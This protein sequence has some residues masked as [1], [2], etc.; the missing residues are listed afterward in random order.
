MPLGAMA[1]ARPCFFSVAQCS[2]STSSTDRQPSD[3]ATS[4]VL[5]TLHLS[6]NRLKHQKTIDCLML[7]FSASAGLSSAPSSEATAGVRAETAALASTCLR[8]NER[9]GGPREWEW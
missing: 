3:F 2:G 1:Q 9:M 8:L 4:Q 6:P 5:A 7:P